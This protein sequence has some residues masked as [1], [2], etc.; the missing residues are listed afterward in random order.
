[1]KKNWSTRVRPYTPAYARVS[2]RAYCSWNNEEEADLVRCYQNGMK[3]I[4]LADRH[5]RTV[6]AIECR[7]ERLLDYEK[8]GY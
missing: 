5:K 7:L 8:V 3:L 4:E 6:N 1:M 2:K